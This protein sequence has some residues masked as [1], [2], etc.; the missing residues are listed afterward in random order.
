[1][2]RKPEKSTIPA[3]PEQR[4]DR[5]FP[6]RMGTNDRSLPLGG[7][8]L[9]NICPYEKVI[10]IA[11]SV[12]NPATVGAVLVATKTS[13]PILEQQRDRRDGRSSL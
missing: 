3:T 10:T 12:H 8:W 11:R 5:L 6:A 4:H 13:K 1:M 2:T 7:A 9:R